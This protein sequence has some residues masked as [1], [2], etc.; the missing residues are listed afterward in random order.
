MTWGEQC[1]FPEIVID[2]SGSLFGVQIGSK[3]DLSNNIGI[4]SSGNDGAAGS[5]T[6]SQSASG[7]IGNSHNDY[8]SGRPNAPVDSKFGKM[9]DNLRLESRTTIFWRGYTG[10][11]VGI[12][13]NVENFALAG[14]Q[15]LISQDKGL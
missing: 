11:K 6:I 14:R 7:F 15:W 12:S 13:F 9:R 2:S 3:R 8:L 4:D 1:S 5:L 10:S